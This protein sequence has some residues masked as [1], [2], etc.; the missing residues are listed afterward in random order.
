M[1]CN[2]LEGGKLNTSPLK[3]IFFMIEISIIFLC[4]LSDMVT[5]TKNWDSHG[6]HTSVIQNNYKFIPKWP[7]ISLQT[8]SKKEP[9]RGQTD[10]LRVRSGNEFSFLASPSGGGRRRKDSLWTKMSF[11][12]KWSLTYCDLELY[13]WMKLNTLPGW[14]FGNQWT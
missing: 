10:S 5:C 6:Q 3:A 7:G 13:L 4:F 8:D 14:N 9:F 11:L 1:P 2:L 12:P